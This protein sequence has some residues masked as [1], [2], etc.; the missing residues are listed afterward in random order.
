MRE[1]NSGV[2]LVYKSKSFDGRIDKS[3]LPRTVIFVLRLKLHQSQINLSLHNEFIVQF[4][5]GQ[6]SCWGFYC[7]VHQRNI[8]VTS[9]QRN[10]FRA[11]QDW[12]S[13]LR[14]RQTMPVSLSPLIF[15]AAQA[16]F[17]ARLAAGPV[18]AA[19]VI[20]EISVADNGN[21]CGTKGSSSAVASVSSGLTGS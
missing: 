3:G 10:D 21:A 14:Q 19:S 15:Q 18:S 5:P 7:S 12:N 1:R 16:A 2:G 6:E 8:G 20:C 9:C 17:A 11:D 13:S 4:G